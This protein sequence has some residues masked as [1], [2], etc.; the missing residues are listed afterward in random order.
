[1]P[2]F[3]VLL[4]FWVDPFLVVGDGVY[5]FV[6]AIL[7][8]NTVAPAVSIYFMFK[9]GQI[10]S[11]EVEN[12][13]Q[14]FL[15]FGLVIMYYLIAYVLLRLKLNTLPEEIYAM[16]CALLFTLLVCMIISTR[17]KISMHLMSHGALFGVLAALGMVHGLD[18][19]IWVIIS[20]LVGAVV[21]ISRHRIG[22]HTPDQTLS[23][24]LL[25]A[26]IHFFF[27]SNALYL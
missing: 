18:L 11:L 27:V 26:V 16:L 22:V 17:Y 13:K 24:W 6:L 7:A 1:M 21:A 9:F 19:R 5:K 10:S 3:T 8:I 12:R 15:P 23:G 25:G 14:R 4:I 20:I 2:L